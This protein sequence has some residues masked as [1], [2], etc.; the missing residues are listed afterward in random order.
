M[1][2]PFSLQ[3]L[4]GGQLVP[5]GSEVPQNVATA[6]AENSAAG[7]LA[8]TLADAAE[9]G[10]AVV[11]FWR[12]Y[13]REYLTQL[14]QSPPFDPAG[15]WETVPVP[16]EIDDW[17]ARAPLGRGLEYL[18]VD[19]LAA[20]WR[21]MDQ[22]AAVEVAGEAHSIEGW[23]KRRNPLWRMVG[24]VTFHLAENPR[25]EDF[26]FAFLATYTHRLSSGGG[27]R[28]L[29]LGQA[30][31]EFAGQKNT[32]A[33]QSL[34]HP[35]R[36]AAESCELARQLLESRR[37]FHA[38]AWT[39]REAHGFIQAIPA[40]EE[41]GLIVKVPDW[42]RGRRPSRPRV[43]V[44]VDAVGRTSVGIDS[45]MGFRVDLALGNERLSREE[46]QEALAAGE[47]L[48]RLKGQ[49][50]EVDR[51]RLAAVLERWEKAERA[52]AHGF[53]F[54]EGMRLLAG[55]PTTAGGAV[56]GEAEWTN[57]QAGGRLRE[58]LETLR[59]PSRAVQAVGGLELRAD[60]RP[61]QRQGV[62]WLW[63]LHQ[64]G[65]GGC[66]ADD[67]GL[68]KTLQVIALLL[69][70]RQSGPAKPALIVV[71]ASLLGNWRAELERFAPTLRVSYAHPSQENGEPVTP[72]DAVLTTYGM[73]GR[74]P[75]ISGAEWGLVVIDEA[76]AIKNAGAR[77]TRAVK[78]LRSERRLALT[79]TPVENSAGDLWSLFDFLNPGLLGS[80]S[81]F[82]TMI[83]TARERSEGE[84]F[85]ALRRAVSPF[86]L[87][88]LKTDPT[89][90]PDLPDKTEV[91]A[92]CPLTKS[93]ASLYRKSVRQLAQ[94]LRDPD[95]SGIARSG[96]VLSYLMRFKQICNHPALWSGTGAFRAEESGKFGRLRTIAD[97][98]AARGEKMLVFTQFREMTG[99]LADDLREAFGRAG[100]VLHGGTPVGKRQRLV[101]RFQA[102]TGAPFFVISLKAG[103]TG[104]NLTAASHVVHFDR[105]WN[106]A[107]EDQATDRAF[108]LGQKRNV[109]V[110]KFVCP[111]TI[112]EKI[113]RLIGEKR[114][115][116][117][118][119]L[120]GG[121]EKALTEMSDAEL[122]DFVALDP[123]AAQS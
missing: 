61:Y 85:A 113:D 103:G 101:E 97:Q 69:A 42:W 36:Q 53:S 106:P 24:R 17:R 100:L 38:L 81:D 72:A 25:R 70:I 117:D 102:P 14:C 50:I 19:L 90:A 15:G 78:A 8:L 116:A 16:A 96:L 43:R 41:A 27:L 110:H 112:E 65:M 98:V 46:W 108:R 5:A 83:R 114:A 92:A 123:A 93:Q 39:P 77:Q 120:S 47:S 6:F 49:W 80:A 73:L 82:Q 34:L 57:Y 20:L 62:N 75:E 63:L 44:T 26:P 111:G 23:L 84:G 109:M 2:A 12:E 45:M 22:R 13:A 32:R 33:L 105:W 60:L 54:L 11:H 86:I 37:I 35:V 121:A 3:I 67:M 118:Q 31:S 94:D 71:P 56:E 59:D 58:L 28:Y 95:R 55:W 107:V 4:P 88:R 30:L 9:T 51:D 48:V 89:V 122:M 52:A 87:R 21:A 115:L 91:R 1:L 66:L 119:L 40:F 7:L 10:D 68:G 64:L 18:T 76:Q 104:L 79:G 29:P 74:R 99:P